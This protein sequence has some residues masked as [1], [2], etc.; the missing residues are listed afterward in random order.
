MRT[1]PNS[2]TKEDSSSDIDSGEEDEDDE[3]DEDD[4]L[5]SRKLSKNT[6]S[7]A[8]MIFEQV[9]NDKKLNSLSAC[10]H[11]KLISKKTLD[12]QSLRKSLK[13]FLARTRPSTKVLKQSISSFV[14]GGKDNNV[15]I[16]FYTMYQY[17][18]EK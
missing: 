11:A 17:L 4:D 13:H 12:A 9:K 5:Y 2:E 14:S 6:K 18:C 1:I 8:K 7:I 15:F 3:D 10:F 16:F